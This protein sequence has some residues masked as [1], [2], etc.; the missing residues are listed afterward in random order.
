MLRIRPFLNTDAPAL[1]EIWRGQPPARA[2]VQPMTPALLERYVFS[3]PYFDRKHLL[4]AFDGDSPVGFVHTACGPSADLSTT[5]PRHGVVAMLMV[6]PRNDRTELA[7]ELLRQAETMLANDGASS[8]TAIGCWPNAPFY[9]GMYGG[10]RLPGVLETDAALLRWFQAAGYQAT[11]RQVVMRLSLSSFRPLVNRQQLQVRRKYQMTTD[12]DPNPDSWW[13]ACTLGQMNRTRFALSARD[14]R[15][16][17]S[18]DYLDLEPLASSWGVHAA[19][20]SQVNCEPN[21]QRQGLAMFLIGESIKQLQTQGFTMIEA[22]V[23]ETN[24]PALRLLA[25]LGFEV[26]DFGQVLVKSLPQP[27]DAE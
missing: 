15:S 23:D 20:L 2:L 17:A 18:V 25:K 26:E 5:D 3:K 24:Q 19:T 7:A 1:A 6:M 8:L 22:A 10:G 21:C 27:P 14:A 9:H 16:V 11:A 4:L 13:E 12:L